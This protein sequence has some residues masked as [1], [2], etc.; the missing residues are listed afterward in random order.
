MLRAVGSVPPMVLFDAPDDDRD[1]HR[2]GEGCSPVTSVPM[3]L[4]S[5]WLFIVPASLIRIPAPL[6]PEM[7]LPAC[8]SVPPMVLFDAPFTIATP[9]PLA[10]G[11]VAGHV[12]ADEVALDPVVHRAVSL[13]RIPSPL[14]PEMR[15]PP[16]QR[17]RRS[18]YRMLLPTIC[19]PLPLPRGAEPA[20][21]VPI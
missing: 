19:T 21:L 12:G 16:L 1:A 7:T 18:R 8:G 9:A 17:S 14:F 13:I 2:V 20:R 15:L 5:T 11:V 4:P 6:F 10:T 3:K